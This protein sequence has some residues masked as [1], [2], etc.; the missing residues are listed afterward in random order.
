MLNKLFNKYP[1]E[2]GFSVSHTTR[3]PRAGE[4]DGEQYNFV[5]RDEF[6]SRVQNGEFLEWAEFGGNW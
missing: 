4:K 3:S 1:G 5:S 6:M 2:F